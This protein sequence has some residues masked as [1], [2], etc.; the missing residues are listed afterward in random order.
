[1]RNIALLTGANGQ[2]G[3]LLLK[4][5]VKKYYVICLDNKY[6]KLKILKN[7]IKYK[8]DISNENDVKIFLNFLSK[9]KITRINT[10]IN[11]AAIQNFESIENESFED[12][13]NVLKVN[14]GGSFL[15]KHSAF[16]F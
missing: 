8:L 4:N 7:C 11:N 5:L 15:I 12:F 16:I 2:I 13:M 9:N 3:K 14:V 10:L 1:M 6:S